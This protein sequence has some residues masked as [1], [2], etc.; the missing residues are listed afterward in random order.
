MKKSLLSFL[1]IISAIYYGCEKDFDSVVDQS[2]VLYQVTGVRTIDSVRYIPNDSLVLITIAFNKSIDLRSVFTDIYASDGSKLNNNSFSLL[3]NG[4]TENGDLV[5]GDNTFSNKFP[6]SE[7]YP[8]GTY[9]INYYTE[10]KN[11][12][13][14]QVAIQNFKYD[15]GQA[16]VV[17]IISNLII[18]DTI[19]RG[20]SF[21][22]SVVASDSNGLNDIEYVYFELFRPDSSQVFPS[23]GVTK[24]IMH[25]DGNFD[26]F[27]DQ[28]A[29]DGIF[30]FKNSFGT[31]S[32][33][34]KWRFVFQAIDRGKKFSNILTHFMQVQ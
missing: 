17:P 19:T 33:I 27:G 34:G 20:V 8:N 30:S 18:T 25:D 26:V 2:P 6:L 12:S 11:N 3:D 9:T 7:F 21:I 4:K 5:A 23:P 31:S 10:D 22:F 13:I 16:N 32:Q 28:T 15:N 24:F 29:G 14:K 1:L